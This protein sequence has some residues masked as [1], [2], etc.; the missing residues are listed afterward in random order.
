MIDLFLNFNKTERTLLIGAGICAIVTASVYPILTRMGYPDG[1]AVQI[2]IYFARTGG[3]L[4]SIAIAMAMWRY[5]RPVRAGEAP[6]EGA[7]DPDQAPKVKPAKPKE[8]GDSAK[9]GQR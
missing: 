3:V 2:I 8:S 9:P 7:W 5:M 6:G 1:L 4:L